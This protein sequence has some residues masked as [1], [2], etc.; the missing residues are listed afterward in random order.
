MRVAVTGSSGLI[1]SAVVRRLN[2]AGHQVIGVVRTPSSS[3]SQP[4]V[5]WDPTSGRIDDDA[6]EG[7]DAVLHLAGEPI[8]ARRWSP[9]QKQRIA[10]SRL[11]GTSLLAD[12]LAGLD[13]PPTVL[14]SASAIGFYG[15]RGDE[16][17]TE[18]SARGDGFLA[19]VC[20]GWEA[21]TESAGRAGI[22]VVLARTGVVLSP[23]GGALAEMLPFFRLGLGGRVGRGDQWMSWI[24]L[25]DEVE[26]LVWLI[27]AADAQITGPVNLTAPEPVTNRQFTA[28]LGRALRRPAFLPTPKLALSARVGRELAEALLYSSAR[29]EPA[30]LERNGFSFAH[31]NISEALSALV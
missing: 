24:T 19:E 23:D 2:S 17:L 14:V 9:E 13:D 15:D 30:V 6:F 4:Q 10:D 28:A 3:G 29:V 8:A 20:A 26:A 1:G 11:Q 22:R 18:E 21:A 16:R 31:R 12:A 27:E 5:A 25:H 7:V